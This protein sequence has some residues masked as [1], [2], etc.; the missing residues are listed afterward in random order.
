MKYNNNDKIG[1][2]QAPTTNKMVIVKL[3]FILPLYS[4]YK[5]A[6][7]EIINIVVVPNANV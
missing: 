3:N 2:M 7:F 6:P 4:V 1:G 5:M